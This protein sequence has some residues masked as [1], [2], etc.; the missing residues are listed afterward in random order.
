LCCKVRDLVECMLRK[1]PVNRLG[2]VRRASLGEDAA[3][4]D[5]TAIK[6]HPFFKLR[7][8]DEG[9]VDEGVDWSRLLYE[10]ACIV[11][12]LDSPEDTS[13]FDN[14]TDRYVPRAYSDEDTD[15]CSTAP[16]SN[17]GTKDT[18]ASASASASASV[19]VSGASESV[20][21]SASAS[22]SAS[23]NVV[24]DG[25]G[26]SG[27]GASVV[28]NGGGVSGGGV[29]GVSASSS[30]AVEKRLGSEVEIDVAS[31][32]SGHESSLFLTTG[33]ENVSRGEPKSSVSTCAA[34]V[35]TCGCA[36]LSWCSHTHTHTRA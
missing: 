10:R 14:R 19:S 7:L 5:C 13:Y 3:D 27:G 35:C 32:D 6:E 20:G 2:A 24:T 30:P 34:A 36:L 31:F 4:V 29:I 21:A 28:T 17:D 22:A 8:E 26:I 18:S 1:A 12:V 11:P 25:G 16:V 23:G 15:A 33:G 9:G